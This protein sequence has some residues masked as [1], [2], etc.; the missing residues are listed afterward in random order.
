MCVDDD[1][2]DVATG[3]EGGLRT[4]GP[5]QF[6][7]YLN[8]AGGPPFT[9][10]GWFETGDFG[11]VDA[12]G[13]LTVTGRKKDIIIRG[14]ENLSAREILAR[15]PAVLEA[16]AVAVA[17]DRCGGRVC[18][19]VVPRRSLGLDLEE[20]RRHFRP[21]GVAVQKTPEV[22]ELVREL[23]RTATGKV[24]KDELRV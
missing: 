11:R 16:A 8:D 6:S 22:R 13:Y 23:R 14:G 19:F 24:R 7:G 12:Q 1:G 17:D 5:E 15:H 18:A 20:L 3:E 2:R 21:E 9:D 4:I 10:D